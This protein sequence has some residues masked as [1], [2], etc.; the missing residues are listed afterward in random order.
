MYLKYFNNTIM[1]NAYLIK[2]FFSLKE[3]LIMERGI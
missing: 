1:Y 2:I 3:T